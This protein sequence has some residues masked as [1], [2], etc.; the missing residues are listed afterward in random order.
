[1][2]YDNDKLKVRHDPTAS[3]VEKN[4]S[5]LIKTPFYLIPPITSPYRAKNTCPTFLSSAF[6]IHVAKYSQSKIHP[7]AAP[8]PFPISN[9]LQV[10]DLL[11]IK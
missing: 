11:L 7:R 3:N 9:T 8:N 10:L 4:S 1:M 5:L 6:P 2:S